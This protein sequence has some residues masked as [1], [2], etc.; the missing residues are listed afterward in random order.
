MWPYLGSGSVVAFPQF[1]LEI[2]SLALIGDTFVLEGFRSNFD[3]LFSIILSFSLVGVGDI[4]DG[5]R[6]NLLPFPHESRDRLP[7]YLYE[8]ISDDIQSDTLTGHYSG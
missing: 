3:S 2:F 4:L 1:L 7:K 5:W 8:I 6:F